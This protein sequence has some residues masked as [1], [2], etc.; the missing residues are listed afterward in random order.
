MTFVVP[1]MQCKYK[2]CLVELGHELFVPSD[3]AEFARSA[4]RAR[5][6]NTLLSSDFPEILEG[7]S[8][9]VDFFAPWCPPCLN[10]LP[11]YRKASV[12][13]SYIFALS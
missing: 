13:V 3:V 8:V 4:T 10:L 12:Q 2:Y 5:N 11:E 9:F 7:Q 1:S 6:L